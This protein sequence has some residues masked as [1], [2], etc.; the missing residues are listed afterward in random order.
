MVASGGNNGPGLGT[1]GS[2]GSSVDGL[3]G[4]LCLCNFAAY[5]SFRSSDFC[6]PSRFLLSVDLKD[7]FD[8]LYSSDC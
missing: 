6:S 5:L 8:R 2:P 3:I 4:K 1:V 7:S